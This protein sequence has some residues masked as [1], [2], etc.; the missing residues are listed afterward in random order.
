MD[1][2]GDAKPLIS[3]KSL[4]LARYSRAGAIADL[5]NFKLRLY[6]HILAFATK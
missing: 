6:E 3:Y 1:G 5:R 2:A 4:S